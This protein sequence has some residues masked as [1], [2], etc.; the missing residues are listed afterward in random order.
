[1]WN[2]DLLQSLSSEQQ[3]EVYED[4]AK[5]LEERVRSTMNDEK[6]SVET[7]ELIDDVQ[8]L[9][10]GYRFKGEIREALERIAALKDES[11]ESLHST[12]LNFR[13]LRQHGF[14]ISQGTLLGSELELKP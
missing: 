10:L 8:R 7:L 1:M 3:V 12:A 11:K 2:D 14:Q 5:K 13:L 4:R 6:R 9:D